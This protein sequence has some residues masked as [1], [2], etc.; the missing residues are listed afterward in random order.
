MDYDS[1]LVQLFDALIQGASTQG[2]INIARE[3]LGNPLHVS[4]Y[5]LEIVAYSGEKEIKDRIWDLVTSCDAR[6]H[7]ELLRLAQKKN[8]LHWMGDSKDP[9]L[10][11]EEV[12]DHRTIGHYFRQG[13]KILGHIMLFEYYQNFRDSDFSYI[14][15]LGD[16]LAYQQIRNNNLKF[17][18]NPE[19]EM[20]L[21]LLLNKRHI[22]DETIARNLFPPDPAHHFI[23]AVVES[24]PGKNNHNL[25]PVFL[26]VLSTKMPEGRM[27]IYQDKIVM[28][29]QCYKLNEIDWGKMEPFFEE[30]CIRCGVSNPFSRIEDI[31]IAYQEALNAL[32]NGVFFLQPGH[33]H[34]YYPLFHIFDIVNRDNNLL[35]FLHP[36][37]T[38]LLDYDN[39]YHTKWFGDLTVFI[40]SDCDM[41]RT[42]DMLCVHKNTIHYRIK[43][44]EEIMGYSFKDAV[45]I[46]SLKLSVFILYYLDPE[47]FYKK[48][49][50]PHSLKI[51][52]DRI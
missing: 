9:I 11:H 37:I 24:V 15:K 40:F 22:A 5:N 33:V 27:V 46:F 34:N 45:F 1:S 39:I 3:Y 16:I 36:A 25:P 44:V 31:R 30:Y 42:A 18:G 26:N 7:L 19:V 49:E 6:K 47:A 41:Q 17:A 12:I 48:Y 20:T 23:L 50:V 28:L 10:L 8:D 21:A 2:L 51:F 4:D 14:K 43:K 13:N 35:R 29:F 38:K 32:E 52:P